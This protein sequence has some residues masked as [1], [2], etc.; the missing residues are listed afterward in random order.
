MTRPQ[1]LR[2]AHH[3][4]LASQIAAV[5]GSVGVRALVL[6]VAL[7]LNVGFYLPDVPGEA[8]GVAVPGIDKVVHVGVFALTV[9]AAGR[10]LAPRRRFPMGWMVLAAVLHAVL[11]EVLQGALLPHRSADVRDVAA[12]VVGVGIGVLAWHLERRLA[13]ARAS[14]RARPGAPVAA[15]PPADGD[16]DPFTLPA[17]RSRSGAPPAARR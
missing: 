14:R 3:G 1:T 11:I 5:G 17:A 16:A 9:W 2:A 4:S 8:G 7:V 13:S 10:L 6:A 15:Q 12:D